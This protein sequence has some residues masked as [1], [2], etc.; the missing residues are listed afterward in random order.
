MRLFTSVGPWQVIS[1]WCPNIINTV[2]QES[3]QNY[4]TQYNIMQTQLQPAVVNC[5]KKYRMVKTMLCRFDTVGI[6][7]L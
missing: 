5:K 3:L 2:L 4:I 7:L 6:H 1:N